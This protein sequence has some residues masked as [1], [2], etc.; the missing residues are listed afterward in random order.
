LQIEEANHKSVNAKKLKIADKIMNVIDITNNPPSDWP[1]ERLT[2]YLD[3]SEKV[4][5]G[6][7]GVNLRLE[8]LFDKC[9]A[10]GREKYRSI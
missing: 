5:A 6:L 1:M 2:D 8:D 9:L 3:W 4:V 10:K 7:R